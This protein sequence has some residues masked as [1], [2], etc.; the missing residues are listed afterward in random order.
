M[1]M[2]RYKMH[3]GE[4]E[5]VQFHLDEAIKHGQN[6]SLV[7]SMSAGILFYQ[8]RFDEAIELQSQAVELDPLGAIN[9]LNLAYYLQKAGRYHESEKEFLVALDLVNEPT[10]SRLYDLADTYIFLHQPVEAQNLILDL[11][12]GMEKDRMQAIINLSLG[13]SIEAQPF[14]EKI[15]AMGGVK[16]AFFLAEIYAFSGIK[17]DAF[18]WLSV[19]A[20]RHAGLESDMV[21]DDWLYMNTSSPYLK[22]LREDVRWKE[23]LEIMKFN[24]HGV[25]Y[26]VSP[27]DF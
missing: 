21:T 18:N 5:S 19:V 27:Q 6:S 25:K 16:P 17:D 11:P 14:I 10:N 23:W 12:A 26:K 20:A 8:T 15:K 1:R 13:N 2:A 24:D 22:V 3:F 4:P 9:R 7:M